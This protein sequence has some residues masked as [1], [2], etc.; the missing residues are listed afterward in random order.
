VVALR[1]LDHRL[2]E[3][4]LAELHGVLTVEVVMIWVVSK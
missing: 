4:G 1:H 3:V 2:L